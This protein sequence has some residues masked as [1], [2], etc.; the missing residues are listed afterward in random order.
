MEFIEK[1][2]EDDDNFSIPDNSVENETDTG[3]EKGTPEIMNMKKGETVT[4]VSI[5]Q[6]LESNPTRDN[7]SIGVGSVND[8]KLEAMKQIINTK[9]KK[10]NKLELSKKV[11]KKQ[12]NNTKRNK[13]PSSQTST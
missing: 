10:N 3:L 7:A 4:E 5:S 6:V 13:P 9:N 1:D 8:S 12:D 11:K 2:F